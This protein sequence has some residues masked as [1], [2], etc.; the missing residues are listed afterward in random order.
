MLTFINQHWLLWLAG[1]SFAFAFAY[2]Y[3]IILPVTVAAIGTLLG[4]QPLNNESPHAPRLTPHLGLTAI[5][6]CLVEPPRG[7]TTS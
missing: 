5:S 7:T 4:T 1:V 6:N 3:T 2:K